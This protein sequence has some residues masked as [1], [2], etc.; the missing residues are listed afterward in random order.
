[1]I[2]NRLQKSLSFNLKL[3]WSSKITRQSVFRDEKVQKKAKN[4]YDYS[5]KCDQTQQKVAFTIMLLSPFLQQ[6]ISCDFWMFLVNFR[7]FVQYGSLT[8]CDHCNC[9]SAGKS[10]LCWETLFD[11]IL[12][13]F[14][15][16]PRKMMLSTITYTYSQSHR[17]LRSKTV[18]TFFFDCL[19]V[20]RDTVYKVHNI[21]IINIIVE[22]RIILK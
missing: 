2:M 16:F 5:E 18:L 19:F 22:Q 6:P 15:K 8:P 14:S 7:Y 12:F 3:S 13:H 4:L 21:G 11:S 20:K 1:M 17:R 10:V 9:V